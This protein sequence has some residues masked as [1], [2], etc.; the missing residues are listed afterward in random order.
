[1]SMRR[2]RAVDVAAA[3]GGIERYEEKKKK[4]VQVR[5]QLDAEAG[6]V[7]PGHAEQDGVG[8]MLA[9]IRRHTH[10]DFPFPDLPRPRCDVRG[11]LYPPFPVLLELR[12]GETLITIA[13]IEVLSLGEQAGWKSLERKREW[14]LRLRAVMEMVPRCEMRAAGQPCIGPRRTAMSRRYARAADSG[15]DG[16]LWCE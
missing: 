12:R 6:P 14:T 8:D 10:A 5:A 7:Q 13:G 4:A 2:Q 1:M 11:Y 15:I 3:I 9:E 16:T